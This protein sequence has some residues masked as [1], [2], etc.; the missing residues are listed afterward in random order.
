[1]NQKQNSTNA[2]SASILGENIDNNLMETK[3]L[4]FLVVDD[5]PSV[6]NMTKTY[7]ERIYPGCRISEGS[8]GLTLL[9]KASL[10]SYDMILTDYNMPHKNGL[11]AIIKL[12]DNRI[13]T[14]ALILSALPLTDLSDVMKYIKIKT[15][16]ASFLEKPYKLENL[17]AEMNK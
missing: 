11:E 10:N 14:P 2:Q 5:D 6:L 17:K 13:L 4:S 12:R 7:L 16:Y 15:N 9:D 1:M 8:N 3:D